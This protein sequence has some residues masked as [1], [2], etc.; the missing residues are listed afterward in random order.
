MPMFDLLDGVRNLQRRFARRRARQT[1]RRLGRSAGRL[2]RDL[3]TGAG[4][5]GGL[6]VKEGRRLAG[7]V[8]DAMPA[9]MRRRRGPRMGALPTVMVAGAGLATIGGM[10]LWDERRR[11]AMRQR[12]DDV[13]ASIG[14]NANRK[15]DE[16]VQMGAPGPSA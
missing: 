9:R 13:T 6:L 10:L 11:Q 4:M 14:T 7:S 2:G 8:S 12:L 5:S 16:P 1:L 15:S 3:R